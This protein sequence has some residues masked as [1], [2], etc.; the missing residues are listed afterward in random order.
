MHTFPPLKQ[1]MNFIFQMRS[2]CTQAFMEKM[3]I[4]CLEQLEHISYKEGK[5]DS[6]IT[7]TMKSIREEHLVRYLLRFYLMAHYL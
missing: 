3:F 5:L 4:Q 7:P 1:T 2:H 6:L